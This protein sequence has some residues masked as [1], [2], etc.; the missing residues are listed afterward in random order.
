[1]LIRAQQ[2]PDRLAMATH[3]QAGENSSLISNQRGKARL[4]KAPKLIFKFLQLF[5][6]SSFIHSRNRRNRPN[7]SAIVWTNRVSLGIRTSA[8]IR[9]PQTEFL[10]ALLGLRGSDRKGNISTSAFFMLHLCM[11]CWR[12]ETWEDLSLI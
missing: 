3:A 6:S 9:L 8:R 10:G 1:M 5:M 12:M 2:F 7:I 4:C 11:K